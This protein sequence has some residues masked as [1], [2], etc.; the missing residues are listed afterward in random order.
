MSIYVTLD[1]PDEH[2]FAGPDEWILKLSSGQIETLVSILEC[3][4]GC[5]EFMGSEKT[6]HMESLKGA[7]SQAQLLLK[8]T[9]IPGTLPYFE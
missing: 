1:N 4:T 6:P 8:I 9:P 7:V 3:E 2:D 5:L